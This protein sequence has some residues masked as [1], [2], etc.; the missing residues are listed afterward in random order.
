MVAVA[1]VVMVGVAPA[2]VIVPLEMVA[3]WL[4]V[5]LFAQTVPLTEAVALAVLKRAALAPPLVTSHGVPVTFA[6][7]LVAEVSHVAPDVPVQ[8][9]VA[10]W[11]MD[12]NDAAR[13]AVASGAMRVGLRTGARTGLASLDA[14]GVRRGTFVLMIWISGV[15]IG[16]G[17]PRQETIPALIFGKIAV[18]DFYVKRLPLFGKH[19]TAVQ[20]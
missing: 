6:D 5:R 1:V 20:L 8:V 18:L 15:G 3:A 17:E 16:F 7:Q 11:T 13:M 14:V 19:D 9:A 10:A 12:G 2:S 4:N